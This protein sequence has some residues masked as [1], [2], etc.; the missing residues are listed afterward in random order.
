MLAQPPEEFGEDTG[1]G[2]SFLNSCNDRSGRQWTGLHLTMEQLWCLG[3]AVGRAR[4]TLPRDFWEVLPGGMPY[5][6]VC[7]DDGGGEEKTVSRGK[8]G[9]EETDEYAGRRYPGENC[10][11]LG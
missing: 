7:R 6:T 4:Y 2:W 11:T 8:E 5:L 3:I 9:K 1:G 10:K